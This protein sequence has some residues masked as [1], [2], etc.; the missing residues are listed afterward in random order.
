LRCSDDF[1]LVFEPLAERIIP[2]AFLSVHQVLNMSMS[3][4]ES[5]ICLTIDVK[6]D[7]KPKI[8]IKD[9]ITN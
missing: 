9:L 1:K 3:D 5:R 6:N 2:K 4:D 8:F 7:E